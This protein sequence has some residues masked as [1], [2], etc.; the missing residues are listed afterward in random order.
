MNGAL[1]TRPGRR[2]YTLWLTAVVA[3]F[4]LLVGAAIP[5]AAA[6]LMRVT[7]V[8]HGQSLGNASG[9]I[10][11]STP[12]PVLSELGQQQA[13][14]LV[15]TLGDKNYDAIYAST[16]VRTQQTAAPMS[17]YLGLPV[18]VLA[19]LQE[20]EAGDYEGT[21]ESEAASGYMQAPLAWSLQGNL[22]A[23]IPG[24]IDGNEFNDRMGGALQTMYDNGDRNPIVFS[25]GAAMMFWTFMNVDNLTAVQKMELLGQSLSNTAYVVVEGNPEDGWTLVNWN[26]QEFSPERTF[27]AELRLQIRTLSRQWQAAAESV[28]TSLAT[29]DPVAIATALNRGISDAGFSLLKFNR[30][31]TAEVIERMEKATAKSVPASRVSPAASDEPQES[32]VDLRAAVTP[33]EPVVAR[34]EARELVKAGAPQRDTAVTQAA[35]EAPER[36]ES[37]NAVSDVTGSAPETAISKLKSQLKKDADKDTVKSRIADRRESVRA[38]VGATAETIKSR[39]G[40]KPQRGSSS[41]KAGAGSSKDKGADSRSSDSGSDG[42]SDG[43]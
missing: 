3:A 21:P 9:S 25:H 40:V 18:Q 43:S 31:V 22:D 29:H 34:Q 19:G 1:Y 41:V 5:A 33:V 23:R 26:G 42:G 38:K 4:A 24:S 6:E 27:G 37:A 13:E 36:A 30:A 28:G 32:E 35:E 10:D 20:I 17:S 12:G 2:R 8:R 11:S 14:A 16:M 15:G 39:L 7:F